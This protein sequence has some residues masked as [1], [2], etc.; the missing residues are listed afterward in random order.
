MYFYAFC[1][2]CILER[3]QTIVI[4]MP[5]SATRLDLLRQASPV[6]GLYWNICLICLLVL[7]A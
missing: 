4:V 5:L 2:Y 3:P 1:K 7:T 6:T